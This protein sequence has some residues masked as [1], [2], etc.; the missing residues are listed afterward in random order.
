MK[1]RQ[2]LVFS[3]QRFEN[4]PISI[5]SIGPLT[6]F[7]PILN[8][9]IFSQKRDLVGT[10]KYCFKKSLPKGACSGEIHFFFQRRILNNYLQRLL[11]S[12]GSRIISNHYMWDTRRLRKRIDGHKQ[13]SS[14]VYKHFLNKHNI[15]TP[16]CLLEQ[17]D[18]FA[19]CHTKFDCL[20]TEMLLFGS[21]K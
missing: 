3:H 2:A 16:T 18:V 11:K 7:T 4:A 12:C 17:F 13:K 20:I 15:A 1:Y 14:S 5:I 9:P 19:K 10:I 6:R 8:F 21:L